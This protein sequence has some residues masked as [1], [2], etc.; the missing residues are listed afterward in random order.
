MIGYAHAAG[1]R[2]GI[3]DDIRVIAQ[4]FSVEE[5]RLHEALLH[6]QKARRPEI[7]LL[8]NPNQEAKV[9]AA[10]FYSSAWSRAYSSIANPVG[11]V[12]RDYHYQV[13]FTALAALAEVGCKQMRVDHPTLGEMWTRC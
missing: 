13:I 8:Q 7:L 10:S 12:H 4:Y 2:E 5:N 11:Q 9:T 6:I 3:R 1:T